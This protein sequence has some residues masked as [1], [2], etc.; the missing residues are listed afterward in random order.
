MNI[1]L[2]ASAGPFPVWFIFYVMGVAKAQER[3]K[4]IIGF[5]NI[6]RAVLVSIMLCLIEIKWLYQFGHIVHGIKLSA[7]IYSFFIIYIMFSREAQL[8]YQIIEKTKWAK[9]II[10]IGN[11]S[12]FIYLTHCLILWLFQ[13]LHIP[14]IWLYS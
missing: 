4:S 1:S 14:N 10:S 12:F 8:L 11:Y 5:K 6:V 2:V 9:T 7:H 3:L 13:R